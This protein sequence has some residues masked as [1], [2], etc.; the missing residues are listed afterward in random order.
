MSSSSMLLLWRSLPRHE[1]VAFAEATYRLE[2][3]VAVVV[4]SVEDEQSL[5]R[6][7]DVLLHY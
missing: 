3:I 5:R 7:P 2:H 4:F 6:G 1:T